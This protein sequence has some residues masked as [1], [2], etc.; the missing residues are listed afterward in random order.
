L[1]FSVLFARLLADSNALARAQL[2]DR[3]AVAVS[4]NVAQLTRVNHLELNGNVF[5]QV[6]ACVL[7]MHRLEYLNMTRNVLCAIPPDIGRLTA[8]RKLFVRSFARRVILAHALDRSFTATKSPSCL[9]RSVPCARSSAL[10]STRTS[11]RRSRPS[12]ASCSR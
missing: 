4:D 8:L 10:R 1:V 12:W 7:T 11:W 3:L 5:S 6:P 2:I 9:A